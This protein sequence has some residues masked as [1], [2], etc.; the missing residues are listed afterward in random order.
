MMHI[1]DMILMIG[2]LLLEVGC[3]SDNPIAWYSKKQ[4]VF[5]DFLET[6]YCTLA[7][8]AELSWIQILLSQLG[9]LLDLIKF[10]T[11]TTRMQSY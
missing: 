7:H 3:F 1:G 11:L 9:M 6:D 5:L 8:V 2:I 4:T 10:S